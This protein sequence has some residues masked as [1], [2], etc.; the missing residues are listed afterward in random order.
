MRFL[1]VHQ[2][3]PA[4][5]RHLGP[6]LVAR[7]HEVVATSLQPAPPPQWEGV[8]ILPYAVARGSTPGIHP[9][10]VDLETQTIRGEAAFRAGL[11]W[12]AEGLQPEVI[13]A[14]PGWGESMFLKDVWPQARMG[15]YCEFFYQATGGDFDFDPEFPL[16]DEA[17]APRIRMKNVNNVLHMGVADAGIAPTHWQA[18][19]FPATFRERIT[20]VHDG[21]DTA[22][23][24]PNEH[25]A[26]TVDGAL[27]TRAD[28]VVTFANRNLEPYRGYHV[29]MRALPQLL[30][31]RPNARVLIVGGAGVGY[32]QAPPEGTTW[33]DLFLAEVSPRLPEGALQRI[34]FLGNLP[35]DKFIALLQLSSVHVYL[36]YPFVLGWSLLEAMSAGCA[37]VASDTAPVRE[38]VED[39]VTGRLVPFFDTATLASSIAA[40]LGDANARQELGSRARGHIVAHYDLC[41]QCLPRQVAW[42]ESL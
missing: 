24:R 40:L 6:A 42:V 22:A 15:L 16:A 38:V 27:L 12:K 7:G 25:V 23:V 28:E 41:T 17:A 31:E 9:W 39:G 29:F 13:V 5:F 10:I 2:N 32:G 35:Y 33:R 11:K 14:H 3:F 4:Q 34:H 36:T 1:F 18:G 26:L 30:R 21:I 37:V 19:L 20:V 8:R